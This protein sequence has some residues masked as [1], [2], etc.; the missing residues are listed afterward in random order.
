MVL[1][2]DIDMSYVI[3]YDI[4]GELTLFTDSIL[5]VRVLVFGQY[6]ITV[7]HT[8]SLTRTLTVLST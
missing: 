6:S 5:L 7:L 2:Y 3:K 4:L 1:L 8:V